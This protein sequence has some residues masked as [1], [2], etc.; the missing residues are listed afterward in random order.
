MSQEDTYYQTDDFHMIY[1]EPNEIYD[2]ER[3]IEKME[4]DM[5]ELWDNVMMQYI[6][7]VEQKQILAQIRD[8]DFEKFR[9]YMFKNNEI[10]SYACN[11][12]ANLRSN[13]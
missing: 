7:N 9:D 11:R 10:Y 2:L 13:I 4:N 1:I 12:L 8:G 3:A 5:R 6:N